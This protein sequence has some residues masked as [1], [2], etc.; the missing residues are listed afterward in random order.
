MLT[1]FP[2]RPRSLNSTV[3]VTLAK[4]VSSLPQPTLS[5]G[6][7]LVPRWRTM[8]EPPGTNCPPKTFTPS[9][10]ALESRPFLE[11][12]NPFLC[13]MLHLNQNVADLHF[14][15]VLAMPY[16]T[17]VLFLALELEH[18]YFLSPAIADDGAFNRSLS[19]VRPG[20]QLALFL[21]DRPQTQIDFGADFAFQFLDADYVARGNPILFSAG[22]NDCMHG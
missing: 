18:Q 19:Q 17:F 9:R 3:P 6:L 2:R 14:R 21:E 12:P 15:E 22:L 7:S 20:D 16:R 5:P 4:S 13:A 1:N 10:C 8:I 11:L